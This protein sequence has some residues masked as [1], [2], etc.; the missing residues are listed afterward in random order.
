MAGFGLSV[1]IIY[2]LLVALFRSWLTPFVILV[3][4]PLALS[5]GLIGIRLAS[6]LSRLPSD[7]RRRSTAKSVVRQM[8]ASRPKNARKPRLTDLGSLLTNSSPS[9]TGDEWLPT[10]DLNHRRG[11]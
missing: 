5:G 4:V 2:L 1:L 9:W 7:L 3:T 6:E 11:G 10:R 8:R